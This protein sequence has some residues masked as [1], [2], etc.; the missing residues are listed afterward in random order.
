MARA[1]RKKRKPREERPEKEK[2]DIENAIFDRQTLLNLNSLM[3]SGVVDSIESWVAEGK[4][5]VILRGK[6]GKEDVA[7]KVFKMETASFRDRKAYLERD[8]RF[9][10]RKEEVLYF[11]R[12]EFKALSIASICCHSPKVYGMKGNVIVME[13]IG[14]AGKPYPRLKDAP[15]ITREKA[16]LI[17]KELEELKKKGVVHADVSEYNLLNC[18][19]ALYFIDF[20]Q[21]VFRKHPRFEEYYKRDVASLK[22]I[23][24][25]YLKNE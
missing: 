1:S 5:A 2:L 24:G 4:E 6:K 10:N 25:K 22:R 12:K 8:V 14:E 20:G 15:F 9:K 17:T 18:P 13:F 21:A 23:L 19:D 7:L 3:R 16:E 11:V